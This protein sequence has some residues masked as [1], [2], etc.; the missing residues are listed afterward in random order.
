MKPS[1]AS[2]PGRYQQRRSPKTATLGNDAASPQ[3]SLRQVQKDAAGYLLSALEAWIVAYSSSS[4][5]GLSQPNHETGDVPKHRSNQKERAT[6]L[7][8]WP[9]LLPRDTLAWAN[10]ERLAIVADVRYSIAHPSH[11]WTLP[12]VV[13]RQPSCHECCGVRSPGEEIDHSPQGATRLCPGSSY[14]PVDPGGSLTMEPEE[15]AR[16]VRPPIRS[17]PRQVLYIAYPIPRPMSME[18]GPLSGPGA[19]RPIVLTHPTPGTSTWC[20]VPGA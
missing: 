19:P 14:H 8:S 18:V 4:S 3:A 11:R 16:F 2:G 6:T 9:T 20:P 10:G 5:A 7:L 12:G 13:D 1:Q 15:V 17:R